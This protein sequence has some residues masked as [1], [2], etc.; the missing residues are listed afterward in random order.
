MKK[1][2][3][4][5][6]CAASLASAPGATAKEGIS[7][8][9]SGELILHRDTKYNG[10]TYEIDQDKAIVKTDWDI[11]SISLFAGEKWEI[12]AKPKFKQ[13]CMVLD[14]SIPVAKAIGIE[15]SIGS[16]RKVKAQ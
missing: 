5:A 12:C 13:P 3:A 16:A 6:L 9:K 15:G 7:A 2:I 1:T 14:R 11:G 8:A 10:E 4:A